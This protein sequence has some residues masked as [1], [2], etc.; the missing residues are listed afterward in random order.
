MT[1]S[2]GVHA[3]IARRRLKRCCREPFLMGVLAGAKYFRRYG[4]AVL[5]LAQKEAVEAVVAQ[6]E[7]G[8]IAYSLRWEGGREG[9]PQFGLIELPE[10]PASFYRLP[11][12][13]GV[14]CRRS[15]MAGLFLVCGTVSE[16]SKGYYMEW[17][18]ASWDCTNLLLGCLID[19]Q[20]EPVVT[21]RGRGQAVCLKRG[22]DVAVALSLVGAT[23]ARLAYEDVRARKET[24]NDLHRLV[25]AETANIRRSAE[26]AVRQNAAIRALQEQGIL[27]QL[28]PELQ[29]LAQVRL[30]N[31]DCSYREIGEM[32]QPPLTRASVAKKLAKLEQLAAKMLEKQ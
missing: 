26:T 11:S 19:E 29:G 28:S 20:V 23:L 27:G 2:A 32:L 15:W 17:S 30:E 13:Q 3:E 5:R 22:E 31:P 7:A 14:C 24:N 6:L 9:E 18:P 8:R 4:R 16:P 1:F 21:A 10:L 25:N 12:F